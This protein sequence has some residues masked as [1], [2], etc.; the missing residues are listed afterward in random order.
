MSRAQKDS[1][2]FMHK[3]NFNRYSSYKKTKQ[4]KK[5][6]LIKNKYLND[7][8]LKNQKSN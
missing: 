4:K 2:Q 8:R 6:H 7:K 3:I 1:K 5:P